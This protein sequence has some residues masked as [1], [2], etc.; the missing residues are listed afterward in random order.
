M[1]FVDTL[2]IRVSI[3]GRDISP[4]RVGDYYRLF[5]LK[6]RL[7]IEITSPVEV[8]L[9]RFVYTTAQGNNSVL[10]RTLA[11]GSSHRQSFTLLPQPGEITIAWGSVASPGT[12]RLALEEVPNTVDGE[13]ALPEQPPH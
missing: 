3:D 6:G 5:A 2:K 11:A 1:I 10:P 8:K 13:P 12:V 4:E 9:L 7:Q